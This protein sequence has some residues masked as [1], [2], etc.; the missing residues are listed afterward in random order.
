MSVDVAQAA[1]A[2]QLEA[3]LPACGNGPSPATDT[4]K[5]TPA[6]RLAKAGW[7]TNNPAPGGVKVEAGD[8]PAT[9]E[10][11][12]TPRAA[13]QPSR[14]TTKRSRT[15][16]KEGSPVKHNLPPPK[17]CTP[18]LAPAAAASGPSREG[19]LAVDA[20]RAHADSK[21]LRREYERR[22]GVV[23][24]QHV[25]RNMPADV[26]VLEVNQ[27]SPDWVDALKCIA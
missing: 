12:V 7:R 2:R 20:Y 24:G 14:S 9:P 1:K 25:S 19:P 27:R 15:D 22:R 6:A 26:E 3:I 4:A 11:P 21:L 5:L 16:S 13:S 17:R 8:T 18:P 10:K 23:R